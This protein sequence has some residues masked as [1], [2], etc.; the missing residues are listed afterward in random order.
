MTAI[1]NTNIRTAANIWE[2]GTTRDEMTYTLPVD[3][4]AERFSQFG[5]NGNPVVPVNERVET[6]GRTNYT[7][8][9]DAVLAQGDDIC[10]ACLDIYGEDRQ[11]MMTIEETSELVQALLKVR[12][13]AVEGP[14]KYRAAIRHL[15]EEIADVRVML[16]QITMMYND[17][18]GMDA[19]VA[20]WAEDKINRQRERNARAVN[21][22][23]AEKASVISVVA[24]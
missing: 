17:E 3:E 18:F 14:A 9:T 19:M 6:D 20:G 7:A 11:F 23:N 13:A 10:K 22:Q 16:A 15:A 8:L 2:M 5:V 12:R 24:A 21:T 1:A 4:I